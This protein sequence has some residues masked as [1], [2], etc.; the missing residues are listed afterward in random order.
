[1]DQ[2]TEFNLEEELDKFEKDTPSEEGDFERQE[3][4][5]KKSHDI[6]KEAMKSVIQ[7][8]VIQLEDGTSH[9]VYLHS[10]D[11]NNNEVTIEFS[12]PSESMK[13]V[14]Y[15][16]VE[17]CVKSQ[18]QQIIKPKKGILNLFRG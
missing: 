10:L 8:I 12:T 11:I 7:E 2:Q 9:L 5:F 16:H 14:L 4:I 18:I 1:M 13:D 6:I 15:P 17:A 3:R